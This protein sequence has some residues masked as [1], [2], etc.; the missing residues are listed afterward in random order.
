[1]KRKPRIPGPDEFPISFEHALRLAAGGR[2][3]GERFRLFR[4]WWRSELARV[5]RAT[6]REAP[7]NTDDMFLHFRNH[8]V[9]YGWFGCM[10][11]GIP[12]VRKAE[13]VQQR[14]DAANARWHPR[15]KTKQAANRR[16]A[17]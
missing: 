14:R 7:D 13:A 2:E 9:D 15:S 4:K 3:V 11:V 10:R 5:A 16:A 1:M 6:G 12:E 17:S 8:G